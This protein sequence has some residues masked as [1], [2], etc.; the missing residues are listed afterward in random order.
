M[1]K[2]LVITCLLTALL[3]V[4][5]GYLG[6]YVEYANERDHRANYSEWKHE[7]LCMPALPGILI[8]FSFREYDYGFEEAWHLDKHKIAFWNGVVFLPLGLLAGLRRR[9]SR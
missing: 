2:T 4:M 7:W 9:T 8:A 5:L 3:G 1:K 6:A